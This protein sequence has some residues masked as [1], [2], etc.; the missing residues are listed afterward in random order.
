[1]WKKLCPSA[2]ARAR[3]VICSEHLYYPE[4]TIVPPSF[5]VRCS[6]ASGC[7]WQGCTGEI[8]QHKVDPQ[9]TKVGGTCTDLL[10]DLWLSV[11]ASCAPVLEEGECFPA[12]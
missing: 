7:F 10:H 9:G 2:C 4:S 5:S 12:C 1:M 6:S 3:K 11:S 8:F